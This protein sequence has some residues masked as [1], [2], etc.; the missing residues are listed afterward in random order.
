MHQAFFELIHV[1][2]TGIDQHCRYNSPQLASRMQEA[3]PRAIS[4]DLLA[5]GALHR[6]S[7]VPDTVKGVQHGHV[8]G[9][10]LLCDQV[11]NQ[12]NKIVIW[13]AVCALSQLRQLHDS[14]SMDTRR[15]AEP[16]CHAWMCKN[17][18]LSGSRV[19][20]AD[21]ASSCTQPMHLMNAADVGTCC[22]HAKWI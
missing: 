10:S 14:T 12:D 3:V 16:A 13:Q 9:Q 8:C 18:T 22:A 21:A 4:Q 19:Q 1:L 11:P 15:P 5:P 20:S 6:S 2:F 7:L 17:T